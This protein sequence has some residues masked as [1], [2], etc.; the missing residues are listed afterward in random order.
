VIA[1]LRRALIALALLAGAAESAHAHGF[2]VVDVQVESTTDGTSVVIITDRS[3]LALAMV[4]A[5]LLDEVDLPAPDDDEAYRALAPRLARMALSRLAPV[6]AD[7]VPLPSLIDAAS[8]GTQLRLRIALDG[9]RGV[10]IRLALHPEHTPPPVYRVRR[11]GS[12]DAEI[13]HE[14]DAVDLASAPPTETSWDLIRRYT[15]QGFLH[16][17]PDGMDHILFVLGLALLATGWRRLLALVTGFTLAHSLTLA[18]T[19]TGIIPAA[20]FERAIEVAIALSIVA[21]AVEAALG[22]GQTAPSRPWRHVALVVF[23]GLIHGLGLAGDLAGIGLP[24]SDLAPALVGLNLGV[25]AGQV[26]VIA[27]AWAMAGW[28][29][30]RP[31]YRAGVVLPVSAAIAVCGVGWALQRA[32]S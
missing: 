14:G 8:S 24:V 1:W 23:F 5:G 4:R 18:L 10:R 17:V 21:V 15:R 27:S 19:A 26:T 2:L 20:R 29:R 22:R 7:G 25:E 31:W 3:E 12:T 9:R 32:W 28:T 13:R 6:G 30:H 11:V 16:V